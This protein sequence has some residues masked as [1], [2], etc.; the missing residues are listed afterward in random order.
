[1]SQR[2]Y[3]TA[4]LGATFLGIGAALHLKNAIVI[5]K[6]G[7]LGEEFIDSYKVCTWKDRNLKTESGGHFE[8]NLRKR[9]LISE[10]GDFYQGP[11][12]YVVSEYL[13]EKPV[14]L[15]L[16]TEITEVKREEG[17]Y[18]ITCYHTK[19]F[20][21]IAAKNL[22]DTTVGGIG[23][24]RAENVEMSK[25]LNS[26]I[27]NPN[28]CA[29][30][31]L[32]YNSASGLYTYV[33]PVSAEKSRQEAIEDLCKKEELFLNHDMKISSIAP[34]FS[35]TLETCNREVDE[36]FRWNPSAAYT[37]PVEAFVMG[38]YIAERTGENDLA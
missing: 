7:I 18:R 32:S 14:E 11:A 33:M 35:Y 16:M 26:I 31:N 2:Y 21:T 1:M 17:H 10:N 4:I 29:I 9:G 8:R 3:D 15:L 22:L 12:M 24:K 36:R 19:G 38:A 37:N 6:G 27:Y 25:T 23:Q 30:E 13:K 28:K 5:E 20:E 34:E